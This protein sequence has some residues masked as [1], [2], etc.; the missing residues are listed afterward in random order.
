MPEIISLLAASTD[1]EQVLERG[2]GVYELL[3]KGFSGSMYL[4]LAA[5][6][7]AQ[8]TAMLAAVVA[9]SAAAASAASD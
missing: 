4:P 7:I 3:K 5:M 6:V 8:E 2:L 9:S 1:L